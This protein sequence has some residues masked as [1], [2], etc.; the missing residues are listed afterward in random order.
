M[1]IKIRGYHIDAFGHV[2]HAGYIRFM[3]EARWDYFDRHREI[4]RILA[5]TAVAHPTVHIGIDY[6]HPA[7]LGDVIRIETGIARKSRRSITFEQRIYTGNPDRLVVDAEVVNV[8]FDG[9]GHIVE[10]GSEVF[11]S[12]EDLQRAEETGNG[13]GQER[14]SAR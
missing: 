8:F 13:S 6:H 4:S 9:M 2:N 1:Q 3:E 14:R 12:W 11:S 10:T 7:V 5:E